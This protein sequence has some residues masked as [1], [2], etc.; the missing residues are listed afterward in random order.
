MHVPPGIPNPAG[1]VCMLKKYLYGLKQASRQWFEKLS[2]VLVG[3]GYQQ[4]RN[5]YSLFV[6]KSSSNLTIVAVYVDDILVRGSDPDEIAILKRHLNSLFGIKDLGLLHY[7]L[8]LEVCNL[9]EGI[10]LS[11]NPF[12]SELIDLVPLP[13]S[14]V[15]VTPLPIN[16]KLH[17]DS[18]EPLTDCS[19]F[20]TLVGKFHFLTHTRPDISF[21]V[22]TLSQFLSAPTSEHWQALLH[23]L[24]YVKG[25]IGYGLYLRP[26]SDLQIHA[27][28]DSDWAACTSSRRSITGFAV[29]LGRS[30]ISWRS[31][32]QSTVS[33]SS[34]EAEYRAMAQTASEISWLVRLLG[35]LGISDLQPLSLHCDNQSAIH[36]AKKPVFHERTK[37]IEIDCHFTRDKVMEGLITLCFTPSR[38]QIA[39]VLTKILPSSQFKPLLS[40]LGMGYSSSPASLEGGC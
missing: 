32:K 31:K 23:L 5:D 26:S 18:G 1:K 12:S 19:L 6:N 22:Q 25:T 11:Q 15:P 20:R 9:P 35:D 8:G 36:I 28:C 17:V 21:A 38:E 7:F 27:F 39:D 40:K 37:H 29:L 2:S 4:S 24:R 14:H 34:S 16:L 10:F 30:P 33:R 3:L 13:G